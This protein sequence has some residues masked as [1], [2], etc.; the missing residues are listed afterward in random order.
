M[1][2]LTQQPPS[3]APSTHA[4]RSRP[5]G[6]RDHAAERVRPAWVPGSVVSPLP[7]LHGHPDRR[8]CVA[9]CGHRG[10]SC[11]GPR[12][13]SLPGGKPPAVRLGLPGGDATHDSDI[14]LLV[15]LLPGGGNELLRVAGIAEELSQL[16]GTRVD[17]VATSLLRSE[18]SASTMADAV[19]V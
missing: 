12:L 13:A 11:R 10:S 18:V 7:S 17:V 19:A 2:R 5:S 6:S 9:A 1:T 8:E 3:R 15:D 16:L 4:S 14:D